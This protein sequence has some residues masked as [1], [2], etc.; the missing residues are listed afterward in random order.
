MLASLVQN[1]LSGLVGRSS[2]YIESLPPALRN[3]VDGLQGLQVDHAKI[4]ADFQKD[5][6]ELEKRYLERYRP[7]YERRLAIINGTAEPSDDEVQKGIKAAEEDEEEEEEDDDEDAEP[8]APRQPPTAEEIAAAPKGIPGFWLTALGNHLGISDLITER[9]EGALKHL[10]DIRVSYLDGKP[11][12]RLTFYFGP[13]A[14]EYFTNSELVK[15]YY[16]QD[17]VGYGGD[18]VY[19]RAEGTDIAWKDGKDLTVKLE[20]KKQRN[21]SAFAPPALT[22]SPRVGADG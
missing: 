5:V 14:K 2:G 7:L 16:Y 13:G 19:E 3:R 11:G 18:F 1:R 15:T 6:L 17:E 22:Y 12:F 20:T 9:D 8:K 21:K 10:E 4:E